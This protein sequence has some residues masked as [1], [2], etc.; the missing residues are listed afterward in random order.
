[1]AKR[2][3]VL[4]ASPRKNGNSDQLAQSLIDGA[5]QAGHE[6]FK[7]DTAFMNIGGCTACDQ[8]WSKGAACVI[9]DDFHKLE[10]LLESCDVLVIATPV[11]WFSYPAQLKGAI[12]RLYAYGGSGGTRPL[13][14]KESIL[15]LVG[16][17]TKSMEYDLM[18]QA[19]KASM[20]FL[21]VTD[22]GV[23]WQGGLNKKDEVQGTA[24]LE[25]AF[26]LG[27]SL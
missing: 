13:A 12:D 18:T 27:R 16:E 6:T 26:E 3:L 2:I 10:P 17:D 8:C 7:L 5:Q 15:L 20:D 14:F 24:A 9:D 25:K 21:G 22:L 4:T 19:Y 11:Y 1:M 23:L